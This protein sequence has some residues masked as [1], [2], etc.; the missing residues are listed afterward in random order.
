MFILLSSYPIPFSG[1]SVGAGVAR[2]MAGSTIPVA[3]VLPQQAT[4]PPQ[5]PGS[6]SSAPRVPHGQVRAQS[7]GQVPDPQAAHTS[8]FLH[9]A[10]AGQQPALSFLVLDLNIAEYNVNI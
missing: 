8:V 6:V 7:P 3:K 10:H 1:G 5:G 4:G 2:S 9:R